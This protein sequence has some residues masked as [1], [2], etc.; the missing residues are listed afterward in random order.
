MFS[1]YFKALL[2]SY[3]L[4]PHVIFWGVFFILFWE[5]MAVYVFTEGMAKAYMIYGIASF[6]GQLLIIGLGSIAATLIQSMYA[7]SFSIRYVTK[8]SKLHPRKF[9]LENFLASIIF[10]MIYS[11]II[12][13]LLVLL[14]YIR[15]GEWYMPKSPLGIIGVTIAIAIFMY[16]FTLFMTYIIIFLRAPKMSPFISFLP[17]MLSF[18]SYAAFWV[19]FGWL[20]YIIPFNIISNTIFYYYTNT[21]PFTGDII[22]N[23]IKMYTGQEPRYADPILSIIALFVWIIVLAMIIYML[24]RKS[25]GIS[26]EELR[27]V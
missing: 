19:D 20:A 18:V 2:R 7:A 17:L 25:K 11:A 14:A 6:Y 4:N 8:F 5:V 13:W 22:G 24:I 1:K 27:I 26:Y 15:F 10:L 16:L 23:S 21:K 3:L 9:V 12:W